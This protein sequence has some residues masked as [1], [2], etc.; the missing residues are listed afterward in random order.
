VR[1]I[2]LPGLRVP[3]RLV[4]RPG[5]R[6]IRL[7]F[8]DQG[9]R[10]SCHPRVPVREVENVLRERSTWL[11]KHA[12]LLDPAPVPPPLADGTLLPL[13]DGEV[14][15]GLAV[16]G[17][18]S[19]RFREDDARLTV[20]APGPDA[21]DRAVEAWYRAMAT[22]FLGEMVLD[23][24][25]Q[26]GVDVP[27]L[28]IRDTRSRWGSC[29]SRGRVNLSWRLVMAPRVVA[30]YVVV[31]ELAHLLQMNHS[32][33]FWGVVES[34]LPNYKESR[35]WLKRYGDDLLQRRPRSDVPAA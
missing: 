9:L 11:L 25:A 18:G 13:L 28:T 33:T 31:H 2:D 6:T 17:R 16:S 24:A 14:E 1:L 12:K 8:T 20:R 4:R 19:W 3:Y 15:L 35:L 23:R 5:M 29:S 32:P 26:L 27:P 30:D 22:R 21:V 7:V 34:V 10:V